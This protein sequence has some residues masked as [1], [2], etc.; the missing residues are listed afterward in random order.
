MLFVSVIS[1]VAIV[2]E[3]AAY[4]LENESDYALFVEIYSYRDGGKH[5]DSF[6]GN[7]FFCCGKHCEPLQ[8]SALTIN[9]Q[10]TL[11]KK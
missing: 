7:D 2:I 3:L 4:D 6:V 5:C 10:L 9:T 1:L 8:K 11:L